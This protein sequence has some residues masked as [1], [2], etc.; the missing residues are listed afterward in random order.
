MRS[1]LIIIIAF[2]A[3]YTL[4][5]Q[6]QTDTLSIPE[7]LVAEENVVGLVRLVEPLVVNENTIL[8]KGL[9]QS[10]HTYIKSYGAGGSATISYRGFN[11][12]QI[13]V[14]WNGFNINS[15]MLGLADLSLIHLPKGE[16]FQLIG[17]EAQFDTP[18]V[19]GGALVLGDR[20]GNWKP[21]PD[22]E[23]SLSQSIASFKNYL[24]QADINWTKALKRNRFFQTKASFIYQ[25]VENNYP[26]SV[27]GIEGQIDHAENKLQ[28][29][30]YGLQYGQTNH[31]FKADVWYSDAVR[32]IPPIILAQDSSIQKDTNI[33]ISTQ[34]E[35][36]KL[37]GL[38]W[39]SAYF[40]EYF[41]FNGS[42]SR[43]HNIHQRFFFMTQA[44]T[45]FYLIPVIKIEYNKAITE[46]YDQWQDRF[47][48]TAQLS[49]YQF[50]NVPFNLFG[51][52]QLSMMDNQVLSPVG[53]IGLSFAAV[54]FRMDYTFNR[55]QRIP[56]LNDLYWVPGGNLD[57][58]TEKSWSHEFTIE[59]K[60]SKRH[61]SLQ[62]LFR[63][64]YYHTKVSDWIEW[65]PSDQGFWMAQNIKK[66]KSVGFDFTYESAWEINPN[67]QLK[68]N[69]TWQYNRTTNLESNNN[70]LEGK[71]LIYRPL[72]QLATQWQL[73]FQ[74]LYIGLGA[75][76]TS[77]RYITSNNDQY[78]E[79]YL[80]AN[81]SIAKAWGIKNLKINT[82]FSTNNIFNQSY[83]QLVWR[84][85]PPRNYE[86][87]IDFTF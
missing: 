62:H 50:F 30:Q 82:T 86:F 60:I 57:L 20:M 5:A 25:D 40:N 47:L 76:Y 53:H 83:E 37:A 67:W 51:N 9:A 49:F 84:P 16:S 65:T 64:K 85:M 54:N 14:L 7:V 32:E 19:I 39:Q 22:L 46:F 61:W 77:K 58:E 17:G 27:R 87:R 48:S 55:N 41:D 2:L 18:N 29:F 36:K 26:Y 59:S 31:Y 42:I 11:A 21:N 24:S 45:N 8:K 43:A 10:A 78:L 15:S 71:V 23:I 74:S 34:Y 81:A 6:E 35:N 73:A 68:S 12:N 72:Q 66:V 3:S 33:R 44:A 28:S 80:L 63:W 75:N 52:I 13:A 70:N 4:D 38:K 79:D 69:W 56:T 1:F